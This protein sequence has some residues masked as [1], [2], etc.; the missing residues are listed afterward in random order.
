M[1]TWSIHALSEF[2]RLAVGY[3]LRVEKVANQRATEPH[4]DYRLGL[5]P[6]PLHTSTICNTDK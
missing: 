5:A 2:A 1:R 3:A 6:S 4:L